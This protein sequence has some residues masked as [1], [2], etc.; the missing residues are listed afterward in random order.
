MK[1]ILEY[2]L[3]QQRARLKPAKQ[4]TNLPEKS[5]EFV[6]IHPLFKLQKL[7]WFQR[8]SLTPSLYRNFS[9]RQDDNTIQFI[10]TPL[11]S[12]AGF[13]RPVSGVAPRRFG[14][15]RKYICMHLS[16]FETEELCVSVL[17]T[18]SL[19]QR[20]A[21]NRSSEAGLNGVRSMAT[22]ARG[23]RC[24]RSENRVFETISGFAGSTVNQRFFLSFHF[25]SILSFSIGK[26][27]S[28]S[29]VFVFAKQASISVVREP[30]SPSYLCKTSWTSDAFLLFS[31][32]K[33][34]SL[35]N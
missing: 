26:H 24:S 29:I 15:T 10:S 2:R 6:S 28:S 31:N 11:K 21:A 20:F 3:K 19:L 25:S 1:N 33:I 9:T 34:L 32:K 30:V 23:S 7:V 27:V 5:T 16:F 14:E 13:R 22:R 18:S 8:Q 4:T 12:M 17:P 35:F